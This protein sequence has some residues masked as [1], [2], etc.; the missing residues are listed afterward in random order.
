MPGAPMNRR[1]HAAEELVHR[2]A[3]RLFH[4]AVFALVAAI[5]VL[6]CT[7]RVAIGT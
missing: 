3:S 1:D 5:V 6:V 4:V 7:A 2:A